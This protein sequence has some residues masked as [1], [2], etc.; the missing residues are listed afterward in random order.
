M[1][2]HVLGLLTAALGT[3]GRWR[4]AMPVRELPTLFLRKKALLHGRRGGADS[5]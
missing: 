5:G 4:T 3:T 2:C 1:T